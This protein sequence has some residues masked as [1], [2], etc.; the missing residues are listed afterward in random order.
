MNDWW[1]NDMH[2]LE[3]LGGRRRLFPRG[4][5]LG[6]V[7]GRRASWELLPAATNPRP[8]VPERGQ[9]N[10]EVRDQP[11]VPRP[12][13]RD[14]EQRDGVDSSAER[15]GSDGCQCCRCRRNRALVKVGLNLGGRL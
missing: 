1:A 2:E 4:P 15:A 9:D 12:L 6:R 3:T 11:E 5:A 8:S 13:G 7:Y 14:L 10:L